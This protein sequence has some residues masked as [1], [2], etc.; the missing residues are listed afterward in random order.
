MRSLLKSLFIVLLPG[1]LLWWF[2]NSS[3]RQQVN[4]LE[5]ESVRRLQH[6]DDNV[7]SEINAIWRRIEIQLQK[8][9][10]EDS[11]HLNPPATLAEIEALESMVGYRLAADYKASLLVHNGSSGWFCSHYCLH[12][13][14]RVVEC[15]KENVGFEGEVGD[16]LIYP[17]ASSTGNFWHPGW[18]AVARRN[19][20]LLI[21]NVENGQIYQWD[22]GYYPVTYQSSSWKAWLE[23]VATRLESGHLAIRQRTNGRVSWEFDDDYATPGSEVTR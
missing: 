8:L 22:E 17:D 12:S 20:Y 21:V 11:V 15:W 6:Y 14:E 13:V 10:C 5:S 18:T 9:N 3:A 7:Q 19:T 1:F 2:L 23:T 16:Y 4:Q